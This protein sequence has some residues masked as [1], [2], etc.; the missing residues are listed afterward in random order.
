MANTEGDALYGIAGLWQSCCYYLLGY[1][2]FLSSEHDNPRYLN[3]K[4][5][6][7]ETSLRFD[8]LLPG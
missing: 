1:C 2:N 5:D 7:D 4:T 8:S 3:M 6:E